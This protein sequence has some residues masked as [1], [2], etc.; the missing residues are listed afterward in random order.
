M[1]EPV[2]NYTFEYD[3][4]EGGGGGGE[5]HGTIT[6]KTYEEIME[7]YYKMEQDIEYSVYNVCLSVEVDMDESDLWKYGSKT[8]N[9]KD[10]L[11]V[12]KQRI[13]WNL[14]ISELKDLI[15]FCQEQLKN[16]TGNEI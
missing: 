7:I 15:A 16:L 2:V 4:K 9:T 1:P 3:W 5:N 10:T 14:N 6:R 12:I 11:R 13:K 8:W